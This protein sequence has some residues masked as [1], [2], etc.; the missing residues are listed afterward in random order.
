MD[1]EVTWLTR[2]VVLH[3]REF[4]LSCIGQL[5]VSKSVIVFSFVFCLYAILLVRSPTGDCGVGLVLSKET[6]TKLTRSHSESR[7]FQRVVN[8]SINCY[9]GNFE[10]SSSYS[11]PFKDYTK[12]CFCSQYTVSWASCS[13]H[14]NGGNPPPCWISLRFSM[15]LRRGREYYHPLWRSVNLVW[16]SPSER[17]W[18]YLYVYSSI[19]DSSWF[20]N[21]L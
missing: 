15:G 13:F 21:Q 5:F 12:S 2:A 19:E 18:I 1:W 7:V 10:L 16:V 14:Y 8:D 17:W 3:C 20:Q 9:C 6:L 11:V 4:F